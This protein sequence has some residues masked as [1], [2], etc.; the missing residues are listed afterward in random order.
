MKRQ[1]HIHEAKIALSAR[2]RHQAEA[3]TKNVGADR[4]ASAIT[5]FLEWRAFSY[6][7]RLIVE[8]QGFVSEPLMVVLQERCPGFLEYATPY[9]NQHPRDPHFL[10]LPLLC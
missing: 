2:F 3:E 10:C 5:E 1:H 8:T 9:A 4:L 6:W 7:L